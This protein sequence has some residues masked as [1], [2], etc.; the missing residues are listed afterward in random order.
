M[1]RLKEPYLV[2][3]AAEYQKRLG[4]K[5]K[6]HL[7]EIAE[8]RLRDNPSEKEIAAAIAAEG[9]HI[10]AALPEGCYVIPL[11][12]EGVQLSSG[13]FSQKLYHAAAKNGTV[14]FIIGG[15]N[16]LSDAVKRRA[17]LLLSFSKLTL[18]HQLFRVVLLEQIYR[19][20]MINGNTKYHK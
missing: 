11:A 13:E 16:G 6:L 5:I 8:S 10:L 18:P 14:A 12:I 19:A 2:Q 20:A 1:G 9:G 17:G 7:T 4:G 15:S 3:A